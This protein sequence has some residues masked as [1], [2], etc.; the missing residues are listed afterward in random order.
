MKIV[1]KAICIVE[2]EAPED[3]DIT[4]LT[5]HEMYKGD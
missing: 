2:I 3:Y 1:M 4:N 5:P